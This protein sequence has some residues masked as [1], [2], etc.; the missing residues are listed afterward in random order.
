MPPVQELL[1]AA[2]AHHK[3]GRLDQAAALYETILAETP[4]QPDALH[5]SAHIAIRRG[6][7]GTAVER[8]RRAASAAPE[9]P[10]VQN[11]LGAALRLT[12][13]LAEAATAFERAVVIKPD[14]A[15]A[16]HNLGL[17][18]RAAGEL[19]GAAT[20][21]ATATRLRPQFALS[22]NALGL[23]RSAQSDLAGAIAAFRRAVEL[24]PNFVEALVNLGLAVHQSGDSAAARPMLEK[25]VTLAP[26]AEAAWHNLGLTR[27]ATGEAKGAAEA[28]A[29]ALAINPKSGDTLNALGVVQVASGDRQAARETFAR[30]VAM[31]PQS[32]IALCNLALAEYHAGAK[33]EAAL[34][35]ERALTL[36]PKLADAWFNSGVF[37]HDRGEF[38]VARAA[39]E[40][41][42]ELDARQPVALSNLLFILHY[43]PAETGASLREAA[44]RVEALWPP[45]QAVAFANPRLPDRRLRIGYVSP[46]FRQHSCAW[47]AAPLFAAHD[48]RAVEVFAYAELE[49][50]DDVSAQLEGLADHWR[51]IF[52]LPDEAVARQVR[53]DGIDVLVDLAGHTRNNRLGV[54]ASSPAPIQV[55]WLGYPGTTGVSTIGHR[56]SDAIADP[57]GVT[58]A[59][60]SERLVRLARPFVCYG[61]PASAPAVGPPPVSRNGYVT[62]GSFNNVQKLSAP[63]IACWAQILKALPGARLRLKASYLSRPIVVER[64]RAAF[65]IEGISAERLTFDGWSADTVTHLAAYQAIDVA[66]DPFPYNGTTTTLEA[67]WMGVPVVTLAGDRHSGRVGVSL[68]SHAGAAELIAEGID[69]YIAKAVALAG[70]AARL[71]A[72]RATLRDQ[73]A[74]SPLCDAPGF[75]SALEDAYRALWR[76]WCVSTHAST[77]SA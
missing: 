55:S 41:A 76:E 77:S 73:L 3:A 27:W 59:H 43:D 14:Y 23:V 40:R 47:F 62:F 61:P 69:G 58:D 30:A 60:Y 10:V 45:R 12:G 39:W 31:A 71:T 38:D 17:T 63:T 4:D 51:P 18:R 74:A 49:R 1:T 36:D 26:K 33:A 15:E 7:Q 42:L 72:Y 68:L 9:R 11:D 46:D 8:L 48:R 21:L 5:L 16:W 19:A 57:P 24:D 67:L 32:A 13:R 75:A 37:A 35:I 34:L 54:F 20:A 28:F 50:P 56:I 52:G 65:A 29:R 6:E 70:D 64:L 53:E 2:L 25:A 66:L 44:R 22:H